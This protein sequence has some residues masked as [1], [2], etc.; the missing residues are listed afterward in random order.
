MHRDVYKKGCRS[1]D[2]SGCVGMREDEERE[3]EREKGKRRPVFKE[4]EF[5]GSSKPKFQNISQ[6]TPQFR[7]EF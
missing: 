6:T 7:F 1:G 3:R 4:N 5:Y 2:D